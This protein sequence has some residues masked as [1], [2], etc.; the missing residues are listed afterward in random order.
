MSY[1]G[2][3]PPDPQQQ[4]P[5]PQ[6]PPAPPAPPGAAPAAGDGF[7]PP[8]I[9]QQQPA[10]PAGA[11]P[12]SPPGPPGPPP[13]PHGG[14]AWTGT[15]RRWWLWSAGGILLA[16]A[17]W[18]GGLVATG[19]LGSVVGGA[20]LRGYPYVK[21]LCRSTDLSPAE[22][23]GLKPAE[24]ADKFSLRHSAL[25]QMS[26]SRSLES[27]D[28][29]RA[30]AYVNVV[31]ERH[32]ETDPGP[33]FTARNSEDYK[34]GDYRVKSEPVSGLGD[35]AY[36]VTE[37]QDGDSNA[38]RIMVRDGWFTYQMYFFQFAGTS[39]DGLSRGKI[40]KLLKEMAGKSMEKLRDKG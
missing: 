25:D 24:E 4:P 5:Y 12:A 11:P 39:E 16:S 6:R 29:S 1:P 17:V 26:C 34:S 27:D 18:A 37:I 7:G 33:E 13:G 22:E 8:E 30:D 10:V 20:D 23:E 21:N 9:L 38:F 14:S 15:G 3:N 28:Y 32:K 31:A 2:G 19:T 35:E 36:L 40:V